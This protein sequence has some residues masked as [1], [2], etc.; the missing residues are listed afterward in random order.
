MTE[1][2]SGD[3]TAQLSRLE[4]KQAWHLAVQSNLMLIMVVLLAIMC[5]LTLTVGKEVS[6]TVDDLTV[7]RSNT[8]PK[9]PHFAVM[10]GWYAD[11]EDPR[12][13]GL[14]MVRIDPSGVIL[15]PLLNGA[16]LHAYDEKNKEY[17]RVRIDEKGRLRVVNERP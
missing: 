1:T 8:D 3:F 4:A 6:K 5:V 7:I 16:V 2:R 11:P 10:H 9:T 17:S 12:K 14:R 15:S 13:S